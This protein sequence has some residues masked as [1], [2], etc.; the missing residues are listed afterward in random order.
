[1]KTESESESNVTTRSIVDYTS[2]N[3]L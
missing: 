2:G 3:E 1:M